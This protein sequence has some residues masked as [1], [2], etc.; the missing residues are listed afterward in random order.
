MQKLKQAPNALK[1]TVERVTEH[2]IEIK[3]DCYD[4]DVSYLGEALVRNGLYI[5][6]WEYWKRIFVHNDNIREEMLQI[7]SIFEARLFK[8]ALGKKIPSRIAVLGLKNNH[9]W[10]EKARQE[11]EPEDK[12]GEGVYIQL[13]VNTL[14]YAGDPEFAGKYKKIED[15]QGRPVPNTPEKSS[16]NS[17]KRTPLDNSYTSQEKE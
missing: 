11:A 4:G 6:I 1:W 9:K 15:S 7:E 12:S 16:I 2:L 10:T 8:D 3:K 14:I 13:D 17:E 5:Q